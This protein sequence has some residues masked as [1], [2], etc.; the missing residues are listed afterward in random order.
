[1]KKSNYAK[2][3][4]VAIAV[5]IVYVSLP[6]VANA[7]DT[8]LIGKSEKVS[9]ADLNVK[10]EADA[11][12]LYRRLRSASERVCGVESLSSSGS[13]SN[14]SKAKRCFKNAMDSAVAEIGNPTLT[15][16]HSG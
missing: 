4:V 9:F 10:K 5:A 8:Q 13:V 7:G 6:A 14:M 12:R 1:M 15:E 16:I 11:R 3:F 2:S